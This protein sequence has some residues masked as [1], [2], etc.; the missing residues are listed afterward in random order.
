MRRCRHTSPRTTSGRGF[1]FPIRRVRTARG[2]DALSWVPFV[3]REI[4][5]HPHNRRLYFSESR[6][7]TKKAPVSEATPATTRY[8]RRSRHVAAQP[9]PANP[10]RRCEGSG[11]ALASLA[12]HSVAWRLTETVAR[13]GCCCDEPVPDRV[14]RGSF[15][16]S[17]AARRNKT[18]RLRKMP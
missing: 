16:R 14:R 4:W 3:Y 15:R 2:A 7:V 5:I 1:T 9:K 10:R 12:K 6:T 13:T 17:A 11:D 8:V 18:S